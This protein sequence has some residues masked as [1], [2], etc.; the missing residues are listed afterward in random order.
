MPNMVRRATV[1]SVPSEDRDVMKIPSED[2]EQMLFVKWF[3]RTYE[4]VRI[5]A[6][7]NG[8]SRRPSEGAKLKATG[9]QK[10]VPDLFVPQWNMWIEM[11]RQKGGVVS[12]EQKDWAEYLRAIGHTVIIARGFE[13][14]KAQINQ[15]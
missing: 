2:R 4:G 6:I 15:A 3:R 7:P 11:K 13:D 1:L 12:P 10:G 8:G 14:A 5:F 9:V